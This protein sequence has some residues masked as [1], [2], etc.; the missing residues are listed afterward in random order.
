MNVQQLKDMVMMG[1]FDALEAAWGE[2]GRNGTPAAELAPVLEALVAAGKA[3]Q[4]EALAWSLLSEK[5]EQDPAAALVVAKAFLTAAPGSTELRKQ[6]A[7]LYRKLHGTKPNFDDLLKASGLQGNQSPRR[8]LQTLETCLAITP[9]CFLANRYDAHVV[10]A[11]AFDSIMGEFEV[12]DASGRTTRVDPRNLAD[13]FD[14]V[15]DQDFRVLCQHRPDELG[16][17]LDGDAA[18][19]LIGVCMV[20][21]GSIDSG[22]LKDMLCPKYIEAKAWS[23]WWSKARTAAKRCKNLALEGRAP[24]TIVYHP[25][26]LT[27]EAELETSVAK[28][29]TPLEKLSLLQ[30]YVREARDRKHPV[31]QAFANPIVAALAEQAEIFREKRPADALAASLAVASVE[32]LG[33]SKPAAAYPA[34]T[35]IIASCPRPADAVAELADTSL[36][37]SGLDALATRPDAAKQFETL[38][39]LVPA[40]S[41]DDVA[42]RV[43]DTAGEDAIA[44]AAAEAAADPIGKLELFVWLWKGPG[45]PPAGLPNKIDLLGRMLKGMLELE[46]DWSVASATRKNANQRLRSALSASEYA[47]Y[48]QAITSTDEGVAGTI[49]RL[50]ERAGGLSQAVRD[51]MMSILRETHFGLFI[52]ARVEP[53]LDENLLWTTQAALTKREAEFKHLTEVTMLEN[54]RAI[55][56]AA[57]HGDLSEN[58]EWKFALE[59]RDMLRARAA[60]MQDEIAK[61]RVIQPDSIST[62]SVAIGAR[63]TL[64]RASD[65]Q[66]LQMTFLGPWDSDLAKNIFSYQTQMGLDL[67]GK[68]VGATVTLKIDNVEDQYTVVKVEPAI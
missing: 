63:V 11:K 23:D 17:L 21:G 41:L 12:A 34:P 50:V 32:S 56:A 65:G 1:R 29:K 61:A 37:R 8:A 53:W 7:E 42:Q 59:E 47:V 68:P 6:T 27:L 58:S 3:D 46:H 31:D 13:E 44:K 5:V 67:M 66:E 20:H 45:N 39:R 15:S 36:W 24:V 49:K 14:V 33:L 40:S 60:K 54:A 57:E 48:R 28:A 10:Q 38:M 22:A 18:A 30:T 16:K 25:S 55:G 9:G 19:V 52:K 62:E 4:A 64:K 43:R 2:A 51:N 26:G 35:D